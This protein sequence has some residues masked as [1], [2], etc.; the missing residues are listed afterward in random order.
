MKVDDILASARDSITA[1]RVYTDPVERDGVTVIA[2]ASVAGGGGGGT[3]TDKE[4]K[5]GSG[6]GFGVGAKPIGAYV[7]KDGRVSWRP[8]VDVNRLIAL[9]GAVAITAL[10][11]GT[12][13][14]KSG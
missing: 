10:I 8:A 11:V 9:L 3:G 12:R 2:A 7:I 4:G 6:G 13:R 14:R 1:R 5:E